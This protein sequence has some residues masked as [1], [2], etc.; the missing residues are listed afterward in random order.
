MAAICLLMRR[1]PQNFLAAQPRVCPYS[2]QSFI[3]FREQF[4]KLL[5]KTY[6]HIILERSVDVPAKYKIKLSGDGARMTRVTG[7]IIISF[8]ILND[9]NAVLSS[10]GIANNAYLIPQ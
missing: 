8:S 10:K 1:L 2:V 5:K 4:L 6:L 9:G 3:G 7:F